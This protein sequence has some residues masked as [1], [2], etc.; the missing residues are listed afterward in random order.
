MPDYRTVGTD[1]STLEAVQSLFKSQS[2]PWALDCLTNWIDLAV[3]YDRIY[4]ALPKDADQLPLNVI[5]PPLM[6]R[7]EENGLIFKASDRHSA[8]R[9]H[10]DLAQV[11]HL[12]D[13]FLQWTSS[14]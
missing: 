4:Y 9:V 14:G 7:A 12:Y 11:Q 1:I 5:T 3:N 13:K 8:N 10:F 2:D 6:E